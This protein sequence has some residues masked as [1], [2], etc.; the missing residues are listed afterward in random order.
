MNRKK[1]KIII[2]TALIII[3]VLLVAIVI[4]L[5]VDNN[6]EIS[7]IKEPKKYLIE[8]E[9]GVVVGN[10]IHQIKDEG[11][12]KI[13]CRNECGIRNENFYDSEFIKKTD[14]CHTCTCFCK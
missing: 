8:D 11:E 9:C 5:L 6:P 7:L 2:R 3:P 4:L 10:L 12:C 1:R 13:K 14:E